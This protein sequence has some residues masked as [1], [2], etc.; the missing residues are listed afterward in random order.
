MKKNILLYILL[1]FLIT[2]NGFFLYNYM[3]K[4]H[5]KKDKEYNGSLGFITKQLKFDD[6]QLEKMK[7]INEEHHQNMMRIK[8]RSRELKDALFNKMSDDFVDKKNIDS[9]T[10]LIG[11]NEKELDTEVFYHFKSIQE[12]CNNQQKETFKKIIKDALQK[13]SGRNQRPPHL[14]R[15]DRNGPPP[16]RDKNQGLPP[17]IH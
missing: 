3:G 5:F 9:I 11:Q 16:H 4:P 6:K 14:K 12:L 13:N 1:F 10:T 7:I 8:L 17:P 15:D 2:V